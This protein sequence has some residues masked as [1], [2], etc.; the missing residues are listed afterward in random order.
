MKRKIDEQPKELSDQKL[1]MAVE[2]SSD[3]FYTANSEGVFTFINQAFASA[4]G[5]EFTE[6]VGKMT[7][8]ILFTGNSQKADYDVFRKELLEGRQIFRK[9]RYKRRNGDVIDIEETVN[10]ITDESGSAI[11]FVG[12][13]RDIASKI[14]EE[15]KQE[16]ESEKSRRILLSVIEDQKIAKEELRKLNEELE[17]RIEERTKELSVAQAEA[18]QA[19]RSKS[20]FLANMSHEIRTPLNAVLG[21]ADLLVASVEDKTHRDYAN[22]IQSSGRGLLTIINDI[23]DLSKIEA[24]RL[25]L[26]FDYINTKSFFEELK[27]IFQTKIAEKGLDFI[28]DISSGVPAGLYVD[29]TRLRQ[30][31]FNVAGNAIKFTESGYVK[32]AVSV[33]YPKIN[34]V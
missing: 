14:I 21:Y 28:L 5:Y 24:G 8:E 7:P 25:D 23:L 29:E 31:I 6:V 33:E 3:A 22:S 2:T 9:V 26:E 4:Y 11:G 27:T 20:E 16:E 34:V 17:V 13:Q 32:I 18:E 30:V 1:R 19:N 12:V 15:Q 10:P